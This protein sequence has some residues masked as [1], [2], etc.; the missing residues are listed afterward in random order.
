MTLTGSGM[1]PPL[2]LLLLLL[3]RTKTKMGQAAERSRSSAP[4]IM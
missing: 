1:Q 4:A 3:Q 2:L